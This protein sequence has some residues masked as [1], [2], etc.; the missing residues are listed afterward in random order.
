MS[1]TVTLEDKWPVLGRHTQATDWLRLWTDFG[2]APERS[3]PTRGGLPSICRCASDP[4]SIRLTPPHPYRY[5]CAGADRTSQPP[6]TERRVHR[7]RYR[8]GEC[9]DRAATGVGATV[10]R[11]PHGKGT[12]RVQSRCPGPIYAR[13]ARQWASAWA[14]APIDEAVVDP[15]RTAVGR[16]PRSCG[17][18][19]G[20][21]L[22]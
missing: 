13:S 7:L 6:R 11:L 9:H 14:C 20:P 8:A 5:L 12:V 16:H 2:R 19:T 15:H 1:C 21:E 4:V 22:R 10:L 3:T 17:R 18:G